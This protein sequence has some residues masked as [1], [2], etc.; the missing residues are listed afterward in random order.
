MVESKKQTNE[1]VPKMQIV[2]QQQSVSLRKK[3][4]QTHAGPTPDGDS[5]NS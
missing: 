1:T 4:C 3:H 2:N 5:I